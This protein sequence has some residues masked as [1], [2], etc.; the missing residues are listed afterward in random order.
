MWLPTMNAGMSTGAFRAQVVTTAPP[1][2][3]RRTAWSAVGQPARGRI[4]DLATRPDGDLLGRQIQ[5]SAVRRRVA[6]R[7]NRHAGPDD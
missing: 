1:G 2:A 7:R 3:P 5:K 4:P 6:L